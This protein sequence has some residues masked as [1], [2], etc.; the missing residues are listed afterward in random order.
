MKNIVSP[1]VVALA[2]VFC[3]QALCA[4]L[5]TETF[6][7]DYRAIPKTSIARNGTKIAS[8]KEYKDLHSLLITLPQDA[9]IR[10]KYPGLRKGV[11]KPNWPA[12]RE[13]EEIRNVR[14]KSCWIVSAKHEGGPDGDHDFHVVV[15]NSPTNFS[16]VMNAEVSAL[17][18]T[19]TADFDTLRDVRALFL[20]LSTNPPSSSFTHLKPPKHV[21]LEGSLYFDGF[22]GAGKKNDPG[23][24]WAKPQSVWEIHPIYKLTSLN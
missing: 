19:H 23:P 2:L 21:I 12:Q 1:L 10:S 15:S 11:K 18:K 7:G 5:G 3:V 20:T 17:P 24:A 13:P 9:T 8:V 16:E 22:H 6:A 4:S 14:I